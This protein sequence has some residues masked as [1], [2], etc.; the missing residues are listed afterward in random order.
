M[1]GFITIATGAERYFQ[2][3]VNL[4]NSYRYATKEP[5]PFAILTDKEN[6][7]TKL[8]DD[9]VILDE[10]TC[11]YLDKMTLLKYTPYD[12]TIFI[13]ADCLAYGDLNRYFDQFS[14]GAEVSCFGRALPMDSQEGWFKAENAGKYKD[15]IHFVTSL[16]GGVIYI[17][18]NHT[19]NETC[20]RA[21][22]LCMDILKDYSDYD[23]FY[24]KKPA[25]EPIYGLVLAILGC[26]PVPIKAHYV[27]FLPETQNFKS[28]II[29]GK[30][31]YRFMGDDVKGNGMLCHFGNYNTVKEPYLTE[32]AILNAM[33]QGKKFTAHKIYAVRRLKNFVGE[34][35]AFIK[36]KLKKK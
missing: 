16:H 8:F 35:E 11:S 31:S 33:L 24:F 36:K 7:Y 12:E 17:R 15:Q 28:N 23:F 3:A 14:V 18:K 9:V 6:E 32:V 19:E 26:E 10:P 21:Y 22:D 4:L 30:A 34:C 1:K 20:H 27:C 25:D 5:L 29:K 2:L 13:D